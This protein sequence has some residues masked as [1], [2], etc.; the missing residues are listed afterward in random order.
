MS[1]VFLCPLGVF[2]AV[3]ALMIV[4]VVLAVLAAVIS[5]F[6]L[7]CLTMNSMA[8]T[9]KAKMSLT[10]GI[11]FIIGGTLTNNRNM[12]TALVFYVR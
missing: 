12:E 9:T 5:V 6:S 10:A 2:Q 8:D 4:G 1:Q 3:R 11:M 7:T